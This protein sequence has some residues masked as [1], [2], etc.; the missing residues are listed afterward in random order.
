MAAGSASRNVPH[1]RLGTVKKLAFVVAVLVSG[2]AVLYAQT[3]SA[4]RG[5]GPRDPGVRTGAPGAGGALPVTGD[6]LAQFGAGA[7]SFKEVDGVANGL[8]PRFNMNS[9]AGCH[10]YPAVGGT[11][12]L[13]NPQFTVANGTNNKVPS[14]ITSDGPV[15][16]ARFKN[17]MNASGQIVSPV[18][19]DGGVHQ[20][21][22]IAGRTDA[23]GCG[24]STS[25][26]AQPPLEAAVRQNNVS[27][28]I[29]TPVFGAGLIEAISDSTILQS[30]TSTGALRSSMGI[31]G[32][33]NRQAVSTTVSV[34]GSPN[35]NGNDGTIS[36]FGWKAQNVSLTIFAG[37]AYNVEQGVTN[38]LFMSERDTEA[39]PLPPGC[40]PN[41]LPEDHTHSGGSFAE[42][43]SDVTKFAVFMRFLAP[44]TPACDSF[45]H[46][47]NCPATVQSGRQVFNQTGCALCHTPQLA[48]G[49]SYSSAI[50]NQKTAQLF[51]DLLLHHMGSELA[52]GVTQG[53]AGDDEFR[54]APL[55]GVGQRIFFL[56]D[57]RTKDLNVA[58]QE[59]ASNGSEA[60]QVISRYNSLSLQQ[61]QDLI[62]FLRS[63]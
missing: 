26:I 31:G 12:P 36:R 44:P 47:S 60:N 29:P 11:S 53:L 16:E 58:I 17:A 61:K 20:L 56:H 21:F 33:P 59:H 19:R 52:D 40:Y 10:A 39:T 23:Q 25:P 13:V 46:L 27:F 51:S 2:S 1:A 42:V 30:F 24:T 34:Q 41:K 5:W 9:C 22:T 18:Q 50:A 45:A 35:R 37:E 49:P 8:G 14:F 62:N 28:R 38:E 7:D 55:W 15:R 54:T 63:L 4:V 6:D 57:G 32:R 43:A 3:N 48:V